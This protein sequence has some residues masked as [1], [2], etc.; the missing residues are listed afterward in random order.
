MGWP[1]IAAVWMVVAVLVVAGKGRE[2]FPYLIEVCSADWPLGRCGRVIVVA[3]VPL[4]LLNL[5][6]ARV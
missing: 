5:C 3:V 1:E 4:V 6:T 2:Q